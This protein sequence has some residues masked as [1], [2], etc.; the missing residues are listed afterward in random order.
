M[1][2]HIA[3]MLAPGPLLGAVMDR[4]GRIPGFAAGALMSAEGG[5]VA[6]L[7]GSAP[8]VGIGLFLLGIGWSATFLV[9]T[10]VISDL[11]ATSERAGVLGLMDLSVSLCSAVAGL[12]SGFVLDL[13][14][15]RLLG[16]GVATAV[17]TGVVILGL[18]GRFARAAAGP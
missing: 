9:A 12:A 14:G 7:G 15:F 13:A 16:L 11:T 10:A 8:I 1:R 17:A 2:V 5:L 3:E 6:G 4:Y 18:W